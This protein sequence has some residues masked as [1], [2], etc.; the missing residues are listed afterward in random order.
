M[1]LLIKSLELESFKN[2]ENV[3]IS[4][5]NKFNVIIGENNIMRTFVYI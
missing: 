3:T 4:F 2:Y 1:A 5:D